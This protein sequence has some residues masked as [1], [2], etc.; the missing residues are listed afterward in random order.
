MDDKESNITVFLVAAALGAFVLALYDAREENDT[1][2]PEPPAQVQEIPKQDKTPLAP[3][4][5][6]LTP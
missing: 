3:P 2:P 1:P 5:A 4:P 6:P